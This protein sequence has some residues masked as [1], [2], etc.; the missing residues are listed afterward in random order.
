MAIPMAT[1]PCST[2]RVAWLDMMPKVSR[3]RYS[4]RLSRRS[5]AASKA[6]SLCATKPDSSICCQHYFIILIGVMLFV[7][8]AFPCS[9]L[10]LAMDDQ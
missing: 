3:F 5:T 6:D 10:I 2:D 9:L 4:Y 1:S 8:V 7:T